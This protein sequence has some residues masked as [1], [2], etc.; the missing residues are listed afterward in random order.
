MGFINIGCPA[1]E[2]TEDSIK[3]HLRVY[4]PQWLMTYNCDNYTTNIFNSEIAIN[5]QIDLNLLKSDQKEYYNKKSKIIND[6]VS[7]ELIG[8]GYLIEWT[9]EAF[10]YLG[11]GNDVFGY[12]QRFESYDH[13]NTS[14][15]IAKL[16]DSKPLTP[17]DIVPVFNKLDSL[18]N[19]K[20][21]YFLAVMYLDLVNSQEFLNSKFIPLPENKEPPEIKLS[22][23]FPNLSPEQIENIKIEFSNSRGVEMAC[24]IHQMFIDDRLVLIKNSKKNALTKFCRDF[25]QISTKEYEAVR[26]LFKYN[27]YLLENISYLQEYNTEDKILKTLKL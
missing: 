2:L 15:R 25:A 21:M 20:A 5:N 24:F 1:G 13:D 14:M 7:A 10:K 19:E 4:F 26:K 9:K 16:K 11:G 8:A 12:K 22:D 6:Y 3:S 17:Q 18:P 27:S 23:F